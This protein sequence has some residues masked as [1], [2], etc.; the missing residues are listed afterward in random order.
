METLEQFMK[1]FKVNKKDTSAAL[2]TSFW[3]FYN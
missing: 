3:S 1:L 2:L